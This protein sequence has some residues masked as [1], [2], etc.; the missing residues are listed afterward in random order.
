[1]AQG[2]LSKQIH[3]VGWALLTSKA[4]WAGERVVAVGP[5][6]MPCCACGH[7][8]RGNRR[9]QANFRCLSCGHAGNADVNAAKDILAQ[10][11]RFVAGRTSLKDA[12]HAKPRHEGRSPSFSWP[13]PP[14]WS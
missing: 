6:Y 13:C 3:D 1:M 4:E 5:R 10:G 12:C 11:L 7:T 9:G 2:S 14:A 8:G